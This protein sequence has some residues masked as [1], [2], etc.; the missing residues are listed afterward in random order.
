MQ[1]SAAR[2]YLSGRFIRLAPIL[3]FLLAVCASPS[4][5][6]AQSTETLSGHAL[7]EALQKGGYVI[8]MRHAASP[9]QAPDKANANADNINL[10]RQLDEEGRSTA[11][12]MGRA[13]RDLGISV[14]TVYSSPTY[15]ALETVQYQGFGEAQEREELSNDP[16]GMRGGTEAQAEWLHMAVMQ[17]PVGTNTLLVT[18]NPN[19]TGAFPELSGLSD[20]EALIFGP[21]REHNNSAQLVARVKIEQWPEMK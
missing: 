21:D 9:R 19:I 18:H 10:E 1:T 14:A 15:R 3:G 16:Q 2:T 11:A 4:L 20:G 8:L 7:V 13:F 5:S 6:F 17:F 12:A